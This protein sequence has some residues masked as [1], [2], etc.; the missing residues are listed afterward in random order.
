ME[1]SQVVIFADRNIGDSG[2]RKGA[3]NVLDLIQGELTIHFEE[4][5][6]MV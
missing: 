4:D 6:A 3:I 1:G 2:V 5:E